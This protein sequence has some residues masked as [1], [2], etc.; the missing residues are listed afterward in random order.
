M[1]RLFISLILVVIGSL[2][3]IGWGL[4]QFVAEEYAPESQDEFHLYQ[5][6]IDGFVKQLEVVEEKDIQGEATILSEHFG[7]ELSIEDKN[8]LALPSAL[9][10]QLRQQG[11]LFLASNKKSYILKEINQS[12]GKLLQLTLPEHPQEDK[13][14]NLAM[15]LLL[16]LGVCIILLL[17][18][19]PLA[20]RL[21]LLTKAAE[22]IGE[23]QLDVRIPSNKYS[24]LKRLELSFNHMAAQIE[25]LVADNKILARS[26]SHD[27]RTPMSCLRFGVEAAIDTQDID[28]KNL[29]LS[30]METEL[31]RMEDMTTA[32]LEYASME[33]QGFNLKAEWFDINELISALAEGCDELVKQNNVKLSPVYLSPMVNVLFDFHWCY[34]ALQN[35]V[36]NAVQYAKSEIIVSVVK[37]KNNIVIRVEDDGKG[38]DENKVDTIFTAFVKLD[39]NRCREQGHFG[40]GLAITAKVV[41]WHKGSI[42]AKSSKKLGGACIEITLPIQPNA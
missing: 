13:E 39:E 41:D 16:Y 30:R 18:L 4:D 40:L 24:Y 3:V 35:L 31:G 2:F 12:S 8:N 28:K 36:S 19:L 27:I 37:H 7:L 38:I 10:L 6:L 5:Q 11:G 21:L 26:L 20:R 32:F 25:K 15:T 14:F 34:Q 42:C 29:Y 22:K 33:R 1:R 9:Q 23:G 17:C